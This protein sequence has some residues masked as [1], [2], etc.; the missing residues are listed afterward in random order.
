MA[1]AVNVQVVR[2]NGRRYVVHLTSVS[3]GTGESNVVKVDISTLKLVD[4]VT[5]PTYT[6]IE[7]IEYSVSAGYVLLEWDHTTDD[8]IAVLSGQGSMD[9]TPYGGLVDPRSTGG[10][11]DILL[12]TSGFASGD[13]YDITIQLRL[14]A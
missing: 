3:D 13:T 6:A 10:T 2:Q 8:E 12:S 1:D 4:G 14:K 7:Y 11:G 9:W 5:V